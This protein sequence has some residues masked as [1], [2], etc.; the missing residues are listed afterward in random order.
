[1]LIIAPDAGCWCCGGRGYPRGQDATKWTAN[2]MTDQNQCRDPGADYVCEACVYV[3]SRSSP[4]P[5]RL[6]GPCSACKGVKPES[7]K[8]AKVRGA[9][10][11]AETSEITRTCLTRDAPT[12]YISAS[13]G[14][15]PTILAWLRGKRLG[16]WFAAIADSGQNRFFHTRPSMPLAV[17]GRSCLTTRASCYPTNMGGDLSTT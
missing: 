13:K 8:S 17:V 5:G 1:M 6:P 14:E 7:C 3:R 10:Q 11:P 16:P 15:K 4:V 9:I 12:P 2:S